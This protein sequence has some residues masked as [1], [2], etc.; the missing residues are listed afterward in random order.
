MARFLLQYRSE[1]NRLLFEAVDAN[2]ATIH[3][4]MK[5]LAENGCL[6]HQRQINSCWKIILPATWDDYLMMLS[7][8]LRKRCRKLQRQFL[9]SGKIQ[10]RQVES[11][12]NLQRGLEILLKLHGARWGTT[13]SRSGFL[14]TRDFE[15]FTKKFPGSTGPKKTPTGV[16]GVRWKAHCC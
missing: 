7:R 13:R 9:D 12:S 10:V 3:A 14:T 6:Y 5:Y 11:E 16:A 4:T 1:W 2:A 8:S 15:R